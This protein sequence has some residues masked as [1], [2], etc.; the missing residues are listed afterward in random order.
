MGRFLPLVQRVFC[1]IRSNF[2][3]LGA[4]LADLGGF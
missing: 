1:W 2:K 4:V 3:V